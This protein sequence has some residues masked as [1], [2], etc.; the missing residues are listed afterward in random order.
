MARGATI[1]PHCGRPT[2]PVAYFARGTNV[3]KMVVL[4]PFTHVVGPL[5]FFLVRKD[6]FICTQ[7]LGLLPPQEPAA[8]LD[9]WTNDVTLLPPGAPYV[10][11]GLDGVAPAVEGQSRF[12]LVW[13]WIFG[14]G[15]LACVG[16]ALANP[17]DA[18]GWMILSSLAG[19]LGLSAAFR[20]QRLARR[21][22]QLRHDER[23]LRLLDLARETGGRLT[24]TSVAA[25]FRVGFDTAER[26]LDSVVD[27]RRVDVEIDEEGNVTYVFRELARALPP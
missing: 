25:R 18:G 1:C 20:A 15:A 6:R 16:T 19:G 3:A 8:R 27:G 12:Q 10:P 11:P 21:A 17:F 23:T 13:A 4:F 7:C 2:T 14:S 26:V 5:L 9:P 22:Q 24:V